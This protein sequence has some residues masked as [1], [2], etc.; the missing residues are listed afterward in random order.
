MKGI[1]PKPVDKDN[2]VDALNREIIPLLREMRSFFGDAGTF[3]MGFVPQNYTR[4][5]STGIK[6]LWQLG[7]HLKGIDVV[8]GFL[9]GALDTRV[10]MAFTFSHPGQVG[11]Q[12]RRMYPGYESSLYNIVARG[13]QARVILPQDGELVSLT[14]QN[15]VASTGLFEIATYTV[16]LSTDG[17]TFLPTGLSFGIPVSDTGAHHRLAEPPIPVL[18]GHLIG[19]QIDYSGPVTAN[20]Q[21][22]AQVATVVLRPSS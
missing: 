10:R 14:M 16:Y 18:A 4:T 7:A 22:D 17:T 5:L 1:S 19:I 15:P 20:G 12:S 9:L 3:G 11:A 6:R 2:V 8:L 21:N 13:W